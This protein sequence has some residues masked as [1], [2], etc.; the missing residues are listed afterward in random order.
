MNVAI[1]IA[2]V[3][4]WLSVVGWAFVDMVSKPSEAFWLAGRSK[5]TWVTVLVVVGVLGGP[6]AAIW[7][8]FYLVKV[9]PELN[10]KKNSDGTWKKR[11]TLSE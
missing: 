11:P 9:R 7:A 3:V 2:L 8:I 5:G 1:P 4:I 6:G 10:K